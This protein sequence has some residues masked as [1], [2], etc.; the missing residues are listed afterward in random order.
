M[1]R[2]L[3]RRSL[4]VRS[5]VASCASVGVVRDE[6]A[7]FFTEA[8]SAMHVP[9][10][11]ESLAE[12]AVSGR[13]GTRRDPADGSA[14][15]RMEAVCAAG[16][17]ERRLRAL[18]ERDLAVLVAAFEPRPWPEAL[19]VELGD[20]T[21]IVVRL[22]VAGQRGTLATGVPMQRLLETARSL[23][24]ALVSED[25]AA[26]DLLRVEAQALFTRARRAYVKVRG[27]GPSV[28][29]GGA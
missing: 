25:H 28:V 19:E 5:L 3:H 17:I 27:L 23:E 2:Q 12:M 26:F 10:N 22:A 16:V 11:H 7:W 13:K 18:A 4:E 9:S 15:A 24:V 8:E 6:L 21:G 29:P 20:L 14:D 1:G